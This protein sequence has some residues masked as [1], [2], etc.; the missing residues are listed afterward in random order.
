MHVELASSMCPITTGDLDPLVVRVFQTA[1][2]TLLRILYIG[3]QEIH[4]GAEGIVWLDKS[5]EISI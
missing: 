5:F 1:Y 4:M 3:D 2:H